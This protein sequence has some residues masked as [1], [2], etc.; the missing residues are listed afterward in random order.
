MPP[1]WP[2]S[3]KPS[4]RS[5]DCALRD[6]TRSLLPSGEEQQ[7]IPPFPIEG[8]RH[9][10]TRPSRQ[11]P[12]SYSEGARGKSQPGS[13]IKACQ[14]FLTQLGHPCF[15]V[16][17]S[18]APKHSSW[19]KSAAL[20]KDNPTFLWPQFLLPSWYP[21]SEGLLP[22]GTGTN[23]VPIVSYLA[24]TSGDQEG[25]PGLDPPGALGSRCQ[26]APC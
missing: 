12:S 19:E 17:S 21:T 8:A 6:P 2:H 5:K 23:S 16:S 13:Y 1:A 14:G 18:E 3:P 4:S 9:R 7:Q 22:G 26:T 15:W 10:Q 11:L 20:G 24:G 25:L